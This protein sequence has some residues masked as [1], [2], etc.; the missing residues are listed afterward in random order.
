MGESVILLNFKQAAWMCVTWMYYPG[1]ARWL[2]LASAGLLAC[3]RGLGPRGSEQGQGHS[4]VACCQLPAAIWNHSSMDI[5]PLLGSQF[6]PLRM[7]FNSCIHPACQHLRRAL[8]A[9]IAEDLTR[10]NF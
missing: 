4:S 1:L 10:K 3:E 8:Q 9:H 5:I 6:V 7:A 2:V